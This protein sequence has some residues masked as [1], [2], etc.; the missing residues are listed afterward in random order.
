MHSFSE[1]ITELVNGFELNDERVYVAM[2]PADLSLGA[3]IHVVD[4]K[5]GLVTVSIVLEDRTYNDDIKLVAT[6]IWLPSHVVSPG[7]TVTTTMRNGWSLQDSNGVS[8]DEGSFQ[9]DSTFSFSYRGSFRYGV[10]VPYEIQ[11]DSVPY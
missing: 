6:S 2:N 3:V 10:A 5:T 8:A 1:D 4:N 7:G 11:P 9:S